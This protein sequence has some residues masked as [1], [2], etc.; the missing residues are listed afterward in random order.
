MNKLIAA[1]LLLS[2]TM[3]HAAPAPFYWWMSKVDGSRVCAQGPLGPGWQR[4]ERP[5]KDSRCEKLAIAK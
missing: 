5:Y 3:L 2:C 4:D 1:I